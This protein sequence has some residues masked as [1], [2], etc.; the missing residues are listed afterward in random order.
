MTETEKKTG[1]FTPIPLNLAEVEELL[2][3][4]AMRR[5]SGDVK[6]AAHLLGIGK[7]TLNRKLKDTPELLCPTSPAVTPAE[8]P[9]GRAFVEKC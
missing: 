5:A 4:E 1:K 3:A 9:R 7:T 2:I 8:R 6:H